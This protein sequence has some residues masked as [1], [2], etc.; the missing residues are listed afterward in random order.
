V[1]DDQLVQSDGKRMKWF[2]DLLIEKARSFQIVVFTCRRDDYVHTS[3]TVPPGANHGQD[4]DDVFMK[5]VDMERAIQ[6][7]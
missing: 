5:S 6:S 7:R 4:T 3:A 1:L 2:R